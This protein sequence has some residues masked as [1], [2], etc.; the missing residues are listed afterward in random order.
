[1][2]RASEQEMATNWMLAEAGQDIAEIE[3]MFG[4]VRK[5]RAE[6]SARLVLANDAFVQAEEALRV[7]EKLRDDMDAELRETREMSLDQRDIFLR[8][9]ERWS[10]EIHRAH[11]KAFGEAEAM[12]GQR[13]PRLEYAVWSVLQ[14]GLSDPKIRT[15]REFADWVC[16]QLSPGGRGGK[17][18]GAS[19]CRGCG[20]SIA[21]T[22]GGRE[23][24]VCCW[25]GR[26]SDKTGTVLGEPDAD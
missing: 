3:V 21:M 14:G 19:A 26:I 15:P 18:K 23:L 2:P 17:V 9:R 24:K 13:G 22:Y 25:C 5:R 8:E 7:V 20:V 1:M 11:R 16:K 10:E 12:A 6:A 4:V